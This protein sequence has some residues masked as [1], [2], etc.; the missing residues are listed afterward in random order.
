MLILQG[1]SSQEPTNFSKEF[2]EEDST[3]NC[4]GIL[5]PNYSE[6]EAS[7]HSY[8]LAQHSPVQPQ[9]VL[10]EQILTIRTITIPS[11]S[12]TGGKKNLL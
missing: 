2:C 10:A 5:L 7:L 9:I 8:L 11:H 6:T 1:V 3:T 4:I 12:N